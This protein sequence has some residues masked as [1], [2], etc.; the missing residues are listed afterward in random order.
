MIP[1]SLRGLL[2][3]VILFHCAP[4]GFRVAQAAE[5][6]RNSGRDYVR[7]TDWAREHNLSIQWIK[8][9]EI[10]QASSTRLNVRLEVHSPEA[11][12]N[13][14]AVRLLFP[15]VQHAEAVYLSRLDAGTT[16][17]PLLSPPKA[18]G[19]SIET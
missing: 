7:V 3:G 10:V 5:H 14:I 11:Q 8:R 13:G 17:G 2:A 16:F 15:L 12:I 19:K 1:L 4:L 18:R 9:E 6:I